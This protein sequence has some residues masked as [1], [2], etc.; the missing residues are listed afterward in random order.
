[1]LDEVDNPHQ[2]QDSNFSCDVMDGEYFKQHPILSVD[3][4]ALQLLG[5]FDDLEVAN[6][7]G[8][9]TK[10]HKIGK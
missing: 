7:L 10:I 5:Y 9:K 6:P 3:Q 8:S 1:M 4:K 2:S